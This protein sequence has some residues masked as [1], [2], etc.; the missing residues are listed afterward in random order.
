M[1]GAWF[2]L[3]VFLLLL[4]FSV[5]TLTNLYANNVVTSEARAA[6]R[7][8]AG[9]ASADDREAAAARARDRFLAEIGDLRADADLVFLDPTDPD[10]I[11][12]RVTARPRRILPALLGQVFFGEVDRIIEVRVERVR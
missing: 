12:A 11:R 1:F 4:L 7:E 8:V 3:V 5:Q 2:G 6:V 9:Y 10:I